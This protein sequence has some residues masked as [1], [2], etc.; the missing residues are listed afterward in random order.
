MTIRMNFI[1]LFFNFPK[2]STL[3]IYFCVSH[4]KRSFKLASIVQKFFYNFVY[5]VTGN[6]K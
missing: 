2:K 6:E 4:T 5:L 3:A 1:S